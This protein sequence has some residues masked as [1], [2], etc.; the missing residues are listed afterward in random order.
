MVPL[1]SKAFMPGLLVHTNEVM[2]LLGDNYFAERSAK[3]TSDIVRRR[4][5]VIEELI[6]KADKRTKDLLARADLSEQAKRALERGMSEGRKDC[7]L[8]EG[9]EK[10]IVKFEATREGCRP[11]SRKEACKIA[12]ALQPD[13]SRVTI[14][15]KDDEEDDQA[16]DEEEDVGKVRRSTTGG[17]KAALFCTQKRNVACNIQLF[18]V[19]FRCTLGIECSDSSREL[20]MRYVTRPSCTQRRGNFFGTAHATNDCAHMHA[21]C[22]HATALL[23]MRKCLRSV[24]T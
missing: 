11:E 24:R 12:P 21:D 22:L 4:L 13:T 5:L 2:V 7:S 15:D 20:S 3:Q 14:Q 10:G 16:T 18:H 23:I 17:V 6:E 8:P 1:G 9:R 19:N